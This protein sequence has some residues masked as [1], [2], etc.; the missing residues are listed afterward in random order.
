MSENNDTQPPLRK[1]SQTPGTY[2]MLSQGK[3]SSMGKGSSMGGVTGVT[4]IFSCL[5]H[6]VQHWGWGLK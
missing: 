3:Y 5:P 2:T 6:F 4:R 1:R